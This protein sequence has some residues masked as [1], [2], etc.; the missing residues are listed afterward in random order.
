SHPQLSLTTC[1]SGGWSPLTTPRSTGGGGQLPSASTKRK[2]TP[3]KFVATVN[4]HPGA[5]DCFP[6]QLGAPRGGWR[7]SEA[8]NCRV[9]RSN[10]VRRLLRPS[11][12]PARKSRP[13]RS[14]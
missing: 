6:F 9:S 7:N 11:R 13:R 8:H 1:L 14:P 5:L 2:T 3:H 12:K 10:H 4:L